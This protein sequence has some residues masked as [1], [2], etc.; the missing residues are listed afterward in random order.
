MKIAVCYSG[1]F[2]TFPKCYEKNHE[3][4]SNLGDLDYY[5]STWELPG[6]TKVAR[7]DDVLAINGDTI[8]PDL[9][10]KDFI[11]TEEYLKRFLPFKSVDI[12]SMTHMEEIIEPHKN[13]PWH[14]MNPCRLVSQYYKL[15][16]CFE[17]LDN[18]SEYDLVVRIRPDIRLKNLPDN[19]SVDKIY[20]PNVVYLTEPSIKTGMINEMFYISNL[21]HMKDIC[22]IYKN[23]DVL[24]NQ[25]DAYGERMSFL[26]FEKYGLLDKCNTFNFDIT[27]VRENGNDEYIR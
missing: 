3:I 2:R 24:W 22:S 23:F 17:L 6:Y 10:Q 4:L 1:A 8:Y 18:P 20:I 14:I 26:N 15:K 5:I 16:K 25:N 9:P 21:K 12:D 27:V 13:K 11:I 19:I 7:F